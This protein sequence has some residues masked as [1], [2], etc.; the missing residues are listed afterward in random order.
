MR[1]YIV[2]MLLI[3][4]S[5]MN[6]AAE[7]VIQNDNKA[8]ERTH[9]AIDALFA[10]DKDTTNKD[11]AALGQAAMQGDIAAQ[12]NLG[13]FYYKHEDYDQ[14]LSWY[15][16]AAEQGSAEAQTILGNLY[17]NTQNS[18][19]DAM[20]WFR[21]AAKQGYAPAQYRLG[22]MYEQMDAIQPSQNA[23]DWYREAA[24]QGNIE[25]QERLNQLDQYPDRKSVV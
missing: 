15:R 7:E 12:I 21:K 24:V 11:L 19:Q 8:V 9:Q 1:K 14:G 23:I 10:D 6:F 18:D 4:N 13:N 3:V 25:A 22:S 5:T 20:D 17:N 16:T 2:G